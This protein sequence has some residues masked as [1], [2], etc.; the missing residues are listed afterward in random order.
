MAPNVK[1]LMETKNSDDFINQKL[2]SFHYPHY[3]S[4]PPVG[5][6]G[7]LSLLW[8]EDTDIV[9]LESSPNLIDTQ[10]THKGAISFIS[11]VYGTLAMEN[12]AA[13]WNKLSKVGCGWDSF[14]IITGD[15]NE[16]LNN[17]EKTGGPPRLEGSFTS[18]RSFVAKNGLWELKH[19]GE[20]LSWRG[21]RYTHIIC[22]RLDRLMSNCSQS[23]AYP[24]GRCCYLRFEGSDHSPLITYFNSNRHKHKGMFRFNRALTEKD[25]V[26]QLGD[27]AWNASPL[28][29]V[30]AKLNACRRRIIK[31]TKEQNE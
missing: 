2:Q 19:S 21:T 27:E 20:Q 3:F 8:K 28:D 10:I 23:E 22:S 17:S 26:R 9:I 15:F 25:E 11:L 14:W 24:L 6:S 29:F 12:R 4:V 18:F 5:L 13:F 30:I 7:G 31:W 1:F 16:I